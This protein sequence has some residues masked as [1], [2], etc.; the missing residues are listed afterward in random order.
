MSQTQSQNGSINEGSGD[1]LH[2]F[3]ELTVQDVIRETADATSFVF[4]V[5]S[6]LAEVF[7]YRPGQF[8]TFEI[9]WNEFAIKRCY[10]LSSA[11]NSD[12]NPKVTVKRID[13]GRMSNWMNDNISPGDRIRVLPPAGLFV[14]HPDKSRPRPLTLFAGGSGITP[15]M[16][17]LK[18]ALDETKRQVTLVYANRDRESVIFSAEL[19]ELAGRFGDRLTV[20]HHLDDAAGFLTQDGVK[21]QISGRF[22]SDFY[23]CG[24]TPFMNTVESAL[25]DSALEGGSIH[26]E[27]FVSAVDPDRQPIATASA[28]SGEMLPDNIVISLEGTTHEIDYQDGETILQAA[29]RAGLDV[30]FSCRDGYC[31]CCMAKL[32]AGKVD[33]TSREALT[34]KE[35][36][37]GWILTCQ[38]RP[39]T[40]ACDVEYEE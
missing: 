20:T 28:P 37:G 32:R 6:A 2:S 24:P 25:L 30:P 22:D 27:R 38:A 3:H 34:D 21:A 18:Q 11:P 4:E 10:S 33:M 7:H 31:S 5:P 17:L 39:T 9:P 35:I 8:L 13:D 16:S 12:A 14:L 26:I 40:E 36:E 15:V 1:P 29:V 23:I 19:D